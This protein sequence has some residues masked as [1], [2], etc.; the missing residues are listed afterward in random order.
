MKALT[1]KHELGGALLNGHL[2]GKCYA[3]SLD[4]YITLLAMHLLL[5]S[6]VGGL[7][8]ITFATAILP[9]MAVLRSGILIST[10]HI[11]GYR[12]WYVKFCYQVLP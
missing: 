4:S 2:I 9:I 8:T 7:H 11:R 1:G 10:Q 5:F 3:V 12:S 6:Y